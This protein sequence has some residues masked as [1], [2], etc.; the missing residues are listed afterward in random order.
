MNISTNLAITIGSGLVLYTMLVFLERYLHIRDIIQER[1]Q[2]KTVAIGYRDDAIAKMKAI[3]AGPEAPMPTLDIQAHYLWLLLQD[4]TANLHH[5]DLWL[6]QIFAFKDSYKELPPKAQVNWPEA[7]RHLAGQH[8]NRCQILEG[9]E[10]TYTDFDG[11]AFTG[12][13][14]IHIG[15]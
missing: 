12:S 13:L 1:D 14:H 3:M 4:L 11:K 2:A 8:P 9:K 7:C 5:R 15:T 6:S 10:R